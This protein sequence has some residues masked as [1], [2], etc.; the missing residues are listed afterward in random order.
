MVSLLF[1][2]CLLGN[3]LVAYETMLLIYCNSVVI[4]FVFN[5]WLVVGLYWWLFVLLF[6][7][8]GC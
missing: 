4:L 2:C 8:N 1:N 7:L 5:L 6:N 3:M